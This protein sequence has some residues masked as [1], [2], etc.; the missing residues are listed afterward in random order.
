MQKRPDIAK[1]L[2]HF[3]TGQSYEA[4]FSNLRKIMAETRLLAGNRLIRGG[5]RCICFTE[6]PILA[7]ANGF[8][9][10]VPSGRYSPFGLMFDK[11][12]VFERGGRPVIYGPESEFLDLPESMRWRHVRYEPS[13]LAPI[14]FTWEREW[15]IRCEELLFS[16]AEATI[17]L[18]DG[19]WASLLQS[20]H[21]DEQDIDVQ[22]YALALDEQIADQ[23][24]ETF[25]WHVVTL[26]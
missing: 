14:D 25:L 24:R 17:V 2:I 23:L 9:S 5:Y 15:R 22:L 13:G 4:A 20:L 26:R 10:N 3:P 1:E 21:E 19:G 16:P 12:W 18:P 7:L 8:A 6:A 11:T